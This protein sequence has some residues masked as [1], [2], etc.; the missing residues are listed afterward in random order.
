MPPVQFWFHRVSFKNSTLS[1]LVYT[2]TKLIFFPQHRF[3]AYFVTEERGPKGLSNWN[4]DSSTGS[5]VDSVSCTIN[6]YLTR[7]SRV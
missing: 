4:D 2:L 6:N 3:H 7:S 1:N 5:G